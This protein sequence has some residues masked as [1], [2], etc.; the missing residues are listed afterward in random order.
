MELWSLLNT[1]RA[2]EH[3]GEAERGRGVL[4]R[5]GLLMPSGWDKWRHSALHR[6]SALSKLFK[7]SISISNF[8]SLA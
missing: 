6:N 2:H 8:L 3:F 5:R 7:H 1:Y 4:Q